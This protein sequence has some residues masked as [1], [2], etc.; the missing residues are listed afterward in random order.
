MVKETT[1]ALSVSVSRRIAGMAIVLFEYVG[2]PRDDEQQMLLEHVRRLMAIDRRAMEI[3]V[4]LDQCA[5][6]D[7]MRLA[8][9]LRALSEVPTPE[10][11]AAV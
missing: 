3:Q 2:H 11:L 7:L 1:P 6:P 9:A 4:D 5:R 10:M 8:N